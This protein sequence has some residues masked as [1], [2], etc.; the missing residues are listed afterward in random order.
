M[1][2][3]LLPLNSKKNPNS[4][5]GEWK[6]EGNQY[7]FK[8]I[9]DLNLLDSTF[10][11]EYK[12]LYHKQI[13]QSGFS[14]IG[15]H[16]KISNATVSFNLATENLEFDNCP[17]NEIRIYRE[18]LG[19]ITTLGKNQYIYIAYICGKIF[20]TIYNEDNNIIA[21]HAVN[22]D[23]QTKGLKFVYFN[24]GLYCVKPTDAGY[25]ISLLTLQ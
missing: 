4:L 9:V 24:G 25:K 17:K 8:K 16:L 11:N 19:K 2:I 18:L 3:S 22:L 5:I 10:A 13:P 12:F 15:N 6:L 1:L 21:C 7:N 23:I 20:R 14:Q